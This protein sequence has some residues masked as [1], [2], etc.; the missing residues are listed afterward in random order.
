M[1]IGIT[2]KARSGKDTVAKLIEDYGFTQ[3]AYADPLKT[4]ASVIF[5]VDIS[6]FYE[7]DKKEA[8]NPFWGMTHRKMLQTLG[9]EACRKGIDQDIWLKRAELTFAEIGNDIVISDVRF[10]NEAEQIRRLGGTILHV[11]S[12]RESTLD[13]QDQK[14]A[15]EAGVTYKSADRI[16]N[17]RGTLE[18]LPTVVASV[19]KGLVSRHV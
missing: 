12:G 7:D 6:N 1:L 19:M 13:Q 11:V 15:S 17:N 3:I 16:V 9:T 10:D 18:E 2:G 5:G 8:F 4:A 14:H